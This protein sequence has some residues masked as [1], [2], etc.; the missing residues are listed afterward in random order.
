MEVRPAGGR[1]VEHDSVHEPRELR[2]E[3]VLRRAKP[4]PPYGEHV[5]ADLTDDEAEAFL[6]AA[7]R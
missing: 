1:G 4:H 3:T 7:L 5:I 6:E 2:V